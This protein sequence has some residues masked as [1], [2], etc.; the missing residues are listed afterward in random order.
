MRTVLILFAIFGLTTVKAEDL[1]TYV[2]SR[3][4]GG[5][6]A[7]ILDYR[8]VISLRTLNGVHFCSGFI[9]NRRWLVTTATCVQH[10]L[11][12]EYT[13]RIA[14]DSLAYD[15][16]IRAI[17]HREIHPQYDESLLMNN[18]A[19]L[20]TVGFTTDFTVGAL[21]PI[22]DRVAPA[23]TEAVVTGWGR[24][25]VTILIIIILRIRLT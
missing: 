17:E 24:T 2:S 10:R 1:E 9:Y 8:F 3:I 11:N 23:G 16:S 15:G 22:S 20:R 4:L 5:T 13:A 7:T 12:A 14:T 18:V 6:S 25:A 19:L 21:L